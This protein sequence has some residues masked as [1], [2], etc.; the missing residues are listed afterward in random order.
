VG[1]ADIADVGIEKEIKHLHEIKDIRDELNIMSSV[2]QSQRKVLKTMAEIIQD[3]NRFDRGPKPTVHNKPAEANREQYAVPLA[4][5]D[6]NI[7]EVNDLDKYAERAYIALNHLLDLK[8]KQANFL[9]SKATHELTSKAN[10]HSMATHE[11]ISKANK[12]AEAT[13]SQGNK[14]MFFTIITIIFMPLSFMTSF[15]AINI[16]QFSRGPDGLSLGYVSKYIFSISAVFIVPAVLIAFKL[17]SINN[18][19]KNDKEVETDK[20]KPE[21]EEKR[22]GG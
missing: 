16:A 14:I 12:Q 20:K 11:L 5:V 10:E 21:D 8:Q 9:E 18:L 13:S 3:S 15:F 1:N 2:F 22:I 4:A 19:F 7:S 17:E 6:H